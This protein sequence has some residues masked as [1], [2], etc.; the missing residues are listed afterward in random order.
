MFPFN[1]SPLPSPGRC[2][3]SLSLPGNARRPADAWRQHLR[4][5]R[6]GGRLPP[7]RLALSTHSAA[8]EANCPNLSLPPL[9]RRHCQPEPGHDSLFPLTDPNGTGCEPPAPLFAAV[10]QSSEGK[11]GSPC[12]PAP[13]QR[14]AFLCVHVGDNTVPH[15][16]KPKSTLA[17]LKC[18]ERCLLLP[19]IGRRA[20]GGGSFRLRTSGEVANSRGFCVLRVE[21]PR[22]AEGASGEAVPARE[23]LRCVR[24]R[25]APTP[26]RTHPRHPLC[27]HRA[28]KHTLRTE[29]ATRLWIRAKGTSHQGGAS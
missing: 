5:S 11:H 20:S 25:A 22:I 16:Q 29:H 24:S 1:S 18:H 10:P 3:G 26:S 4:D 2:S 28:L 14:L 15:F 9:P 17:Q 8:G 13:F 23:L 21:N 7:P 19:G 12:D 27:F 6:A